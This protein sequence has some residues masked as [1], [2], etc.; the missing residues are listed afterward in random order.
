MH[1]KIENL[2]IVRQTINFLQQMPVSLYCDISTSL[3]S[4]LKNMDNL[5][6]RKI[7]YLK[8]AQSLNIYY[9]NT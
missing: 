2:T 8:V 7:C 6:V 9:D 1:N 5:F 4:I 3:K